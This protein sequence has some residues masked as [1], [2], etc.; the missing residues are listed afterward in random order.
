M[1]NE[2]KNAVVVD[3]CA[4]RITALTD[5]VPPNAEIAIDG[6]IHTAAGV[7]AMYQHCLDGR[8]RLAARRAD[9]QVELAARVVSEETRL[10]NDRALKAYVTHRFGAH[11]KEA[12]DFGFPP[13]K[14]QKKTPETKARAVDLAKATREA[15]HTIGP[16]KKLEIRGT[17]D[18]AP[19]SE[20]ASGPVPE[21]SGT[22]VTTPFRGIVSSLS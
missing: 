20:I 6:V 15:R 4:Q 11:S 13:P 16:K 14:D 8:A 3:K 10:A 9:V 17:L 5:H 22:L 21:P 19:P 18:V 2:P 7:I 1:A 12:L